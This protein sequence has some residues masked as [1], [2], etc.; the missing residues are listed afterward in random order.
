MGDLTCSLQS[1][2]MQ[3]RTRGLEGFQQ[4]GGNAV[5]KWANG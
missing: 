1:T 3:L 5:M 4:Y 2:G